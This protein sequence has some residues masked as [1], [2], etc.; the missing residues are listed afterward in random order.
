MYNKPEFLT[1]VDFLG[2]ISQQDVISASLKT[3]I[4]SGAAVLKPAEHF[5]R[6]VMSG[7]SGITHIISNE[8]E[9]RQGIS[10]IDKGKFPTTEMFIANAIAIKFGQAESIGGCAFDKKAPTAL[11]NAELEIMQGGRQVYRAPVAS[12]INEYTGAK[13]DDDFHNLGGLIYLG[14]DYEFTASLH[15][16]DGSSIAAADAGVENIVE[17]RMRGYKTAKRL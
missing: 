17:I 4:A 3:A 15:F 16:A 2:K 13:I 5:T 12:L 14:D 8:T 11:R 9:S 6:K 7:A 10:T 1:A